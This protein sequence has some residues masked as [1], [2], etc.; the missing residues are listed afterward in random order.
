[1]EEEGL[2]WGEKEGESE[3]E[4][5]EEEER[6]R[7][8]GW[9][10]MGNIGD[11]LGGVAGGEG[12][13]VEG[14]GEDGEERWWVREEVESKED[15]RMSKAREIAPSSAPI[16]VT[17]APNGAPISREGSRLSDVKTMP[18]PALLRDSEA[19]RRS[20]Q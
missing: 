2:V 1:L 19:E 17:R 12:G 5:E 18:T 9:G 7:V 15:S 8:M 11:G 4:L 3:D 6:G 10:R 20:H 16:L 13:G 14:G